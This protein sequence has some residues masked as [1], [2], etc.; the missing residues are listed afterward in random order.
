M[1]RAVDVGLCDCIVCSGLVAVSLYTFEAISNS[2]PERGSMSRKDLLCL[3]VALIGVIL[4][5]Y[6]SNYYS[7]AVGWL[8]IFLVVT[9]I[10]AEIVLEVYAVVRKREVDQKP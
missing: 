2:I 3:I 9:G 5:L 1:D 4:F 10:V 8:G 6:G 7:A